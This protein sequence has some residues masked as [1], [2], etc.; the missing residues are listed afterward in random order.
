M[1][2]HSNR[3]Y[4]TTQTVSIAL[5]R[6]EVKHYSDRKY[7]TTQTGNIAPLRQEVKH[8]SHRK[9]GT[10]QTGNL[11]TKAHLNFNKIYNVLPGIMSGCDTTE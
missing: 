9:Y 1:Q 7:N 6:Q 4:N 8:H 5:L 10:I 2:H 3:K 11:K